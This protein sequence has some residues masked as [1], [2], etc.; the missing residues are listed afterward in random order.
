MFCTS[1][2]FTLITDL[3]SAN[4]KNT[5]VGKKQPYVDKFRDFSLKWYNLIHFIPVIP[6]QL[7]Y[8]T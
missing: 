7:H 6:I 1:K 2:P 5:F 4:I 3:Y 8:K